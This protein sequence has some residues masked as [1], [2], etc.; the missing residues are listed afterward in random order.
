M[1]ELK[2][3]RDLNN[4][5]QGELANYLNV[6][7]SFISRVE[8]GFNSLP[9]DKLT[10][11]I[12]NNQGWDVTPLLEIDSMTSAL[13]LFREANNLRQSE[14]SEYLGVSST[15]I[16]L[17]EKGKS[18]LS[19]GKFTLLLNNDKGW[20]TSYLLNKDMELFTDN[21][22]IRGEKSPI[23]EDII[24]DTEEVSEGFPVIPVAL[25]DRPN[26]NI[27][28]EVKRDVDQF[29]R[30]NIQHLVSECDLAYR[31][32]SDVMSPDITIGDILFLKKISRS[33]IL[34]GECYFVDT[35]Y[36]GVLVRYL[37]QEDGNIKCMAPNRPQQ[38][39][40]IPLNE[41]YGIYAIR[42]KFSCRI[43]YSESTSLANQVA[44][45]HISQLINEVAKAG[46]RADR[47]GERVDKLISLLE[48][49]LTKQ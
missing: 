26:T 20:D 29:D 34:N 46:E 19:R 6:T 5:K 22:T 39:L 40:I 42:G 18:K 3:F 27:W 14:L 13:K 21:D 15:F 38:E 33:Q 2:Q 4:L 8:N 28:E 25:V 10:L 31:V 44:N 32:I 48:K 7:S 11:L 49:Q 9:K 23:E 36:Y 37:F 24:T 35:M 47:A 41:I 17:V 45:G 16:S 43:T 30:L 12:E 1:I